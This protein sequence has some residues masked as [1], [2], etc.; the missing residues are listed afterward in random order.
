MN[1]SLAHYI[2]SQRKDERAFNHQCR[3]ECSLIFH[4]V[5]EALPHCLPVYAVV[6]ACTDCYTGCFDITTLEELRVS[7]QRA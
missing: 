2:I 5:E 1:F 4:Q 3:F 7:V 6:I